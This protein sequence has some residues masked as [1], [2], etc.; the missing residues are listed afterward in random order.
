MT[1]PYQTSIDA[2][3]E[4]LGLRPLGDFVL[5]KRIVETKT[6][7]GLFI[8]ESAAA[9]EFGVI[10][11]G[12]VVLVGPG[13]R[14]PDGTRFDMGVEVGDVVL[15][16]RVPANDVRINGEEHTLL[17]EEQHILAVIEE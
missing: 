9:P 17:H 10:R 2:G 3:P 13:D 4:C 1:H 8:P 12:Q 5:V 6:A 16:P 7:G 11:K 14:R 15:Y